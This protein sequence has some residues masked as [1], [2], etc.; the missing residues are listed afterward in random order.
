[1]NTLN[2]LGGRDKLF[3]GDITS[4]EDELADIVSNSKFM[5]VGGAGSIGQAV[6]KEIF[7]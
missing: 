6:C 3:L 4:I 7:K 1:M 2:L 5:V